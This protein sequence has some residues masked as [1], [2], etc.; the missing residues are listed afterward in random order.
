MRVISAA[1]FLERVTY[2]RSDAITVLS[3]DLRDNVVAK[4][5]ASAADKVHVIPNFVDTERRPAARPDDA[6]PRPT[7]DR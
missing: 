6:V 4:L 3:D 5:P 1:Q 2:G 7:V